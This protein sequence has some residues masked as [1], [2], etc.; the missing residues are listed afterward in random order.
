MTDGLKDAHRAAFIA[1]LAANERVERAVL[2]G[3]RAT[4][5]H[6]VTSDVDIALFGDELTE[7]DVAALAVAMDA[8]PMAQTVDP[9][10]HRSI[11]NPTLL[12][13]IA[14]HGVV[15][16]RK[17]VQAVRNFSRHDAGHGG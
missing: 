17:P 6:S 5:T 2:F 12:E 16:Y 10:L 13:H 15:C 7:T 8:L 4:G 1:T 11:D 3:S 14:R 9:V